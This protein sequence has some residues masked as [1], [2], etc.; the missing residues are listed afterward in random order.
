MKHYFSNKYFG[1]SLRTRLY[2]KHHYFLVSFPFVSDDCR[3]FFKSN[4]FQADS[5][6]DY[7]EEDRKGLLMDGG[8][9]NSDSRSRLPLPTVVEGVPS[10]NGA[11]PSNMPVRGEKS[12]KL[13][14]LRK[15]RRH[16][17]KEIIDDSRRALD[18]KGKEYRRE[19]LDGK[20]N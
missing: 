10:T 13:T 12:G 17:K 19:R 16:G 14:R 18:N 4:S 1:C 3:H 11:P 7:D 9:S 15:S 6:S 20:I 8:A 5:D 2:P